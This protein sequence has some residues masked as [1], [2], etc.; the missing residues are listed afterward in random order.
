[1]LRD[2]TPRGFIEESRRVLSRTSK[3]SERK[4]EG[5]KNKKSENGEEKKKSEGKNK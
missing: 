1:M 3:N 4:R 5:E 2:E